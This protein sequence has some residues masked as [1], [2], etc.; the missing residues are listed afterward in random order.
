MAGSVAASRQEPTSATQIAKQQYYI[1]F[2]SS[3]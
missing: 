3:H 2:V 1:I